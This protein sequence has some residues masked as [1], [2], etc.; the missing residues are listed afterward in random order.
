M[1]FGRNSYLK[2]NRYHTAKHALNLFSMLKN[3][4]SS[5]NVIDL[6]FSLSIIGSYFFYG[7]QIQILNTTTLILK[8]KKRTNVARPSKSGQPVWPILSGQ[9]GRASCRERV[10]PYV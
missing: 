5:F 7:K 6:A 2:S 4:F 10:S 8:K 3:H 9:I 1:H